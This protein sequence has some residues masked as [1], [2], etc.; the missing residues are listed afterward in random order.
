M[1]AIY[2]PAFFPPRRLNI[3]SSLKLSSEKISSFLIK[4]IAFIFKLSQF[5]INELC[6][7][8]SI[9]PIQKRMNLLFGN[10]ISVHSAKYVFIFS[11]AI[12]LQSLTL[13]L[14]PTAIPITLFM[15]TF[16]QA[17]ITF[18]FPDLFPQEMIQ[19]GKHFCLLNQFCNFQ[20]GSY[21][22]TVH[23]FLE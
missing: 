13:S 10:Y 1:N 19:P 6:A 5:G 4:F 3:P 17:W 14:W 7:Q 16:Y 9:S 21:F 18:S 8:V 11:I 22:V 23:Y 20:P 15:K 12:S 2:I